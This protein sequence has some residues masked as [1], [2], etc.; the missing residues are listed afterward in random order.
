M[1]SK[2]KKTRS[3]KTKSKTGKTKSKRNCSRKTKEQVSDCSKVGPGVWEVESFFYECVSPEKDSQDRTWAVIYGFE[4][5]WKNYMLNVELKDKQALKT[6]MNRKD[7]FEIWDYEEPWDDFRFDGPLE[8][9][10]KLLIGNPELPM[11][12]RCGSSSQIG[13]EIWSKDG[14]ESHYDE[15]HLFSFKSEKGKER[16]HYISQLKKFIK[17][18]NLCVK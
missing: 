6:H 2:T 3:K 8:H 4:A 11:H 14:L 1:G 16:V 5:K 9:L 15:K 18:L 13:S 17:S 12:F 10:G 7:Y